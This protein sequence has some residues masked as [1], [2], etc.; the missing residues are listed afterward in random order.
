[1]LSV[2]YTAPHWPWET[3]ED[4]AESMRIGNRIL[5][6]DGGS[7]E[8]YRT[9]IRQ[10]DEGIGRILDALES[11]GLARNTLVVFT[12]DNGGERFS[13]TWPFVGRKMDLLEGG[14]RVPLIARWPESI[15]AGG[16]TMQT[17]ITMDWVATM[18]DAAQV[19][20]HPDYPL[21]G[22]SLLATFADPSR[23]VPREL[24]WRMK[25]RD[26]R[27]LRSGTWKYLAQDGFDYLFDLA[28]DPR[29]RANRA[30]REPARFEH[31]RERYASWA[32]SMPA[33]PDEA[34]VSL[35]FVKGDLA[36]P[37]G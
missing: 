26:Q 4:E 37:T 21:D 1:M 22:T 36:T 28:Q 34:K 13:D 19:A 30:Q 17:A 31:L 20:P 10:M 9:M 2:H 5:H 27:A 29:E 23:I 33:V 15:A 32:A 14:I 18:L 7:V 11:D 24:F 25:H 12:S 16:I 35:G 3:R 6:V 8:I